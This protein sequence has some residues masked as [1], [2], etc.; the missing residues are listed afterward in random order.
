[1]YHVLLTCD[2]G[3]AILY[4]CKDY[5]DLVQSVVDITPILGTS[6]RRIGIVQN[7]HQL[8]DAEIA[9]VVRGAGIPLP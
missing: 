8:P 9:E 6:I 5:Q 4:H 3:S 1:M 7:G 2:D